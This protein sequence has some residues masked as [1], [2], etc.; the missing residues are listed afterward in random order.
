MTPLII[1]GRDAYTSTID[2]E[3]DMFQLLGNQ[4][5]EGLVLRQIFTGTPI[6]QGSTLF[7]MFS[8]T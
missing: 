3:T 5:S 8:S 2:I 4:Q 1:N 6:I 7:S